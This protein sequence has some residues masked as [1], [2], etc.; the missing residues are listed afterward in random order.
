[1]TAKHQL[2]CADPRGDAPRTLLDLG[3]NRGWYSQ[4]AAHHGVRSSRADSDE[5]SLNEL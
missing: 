5:T 4:L 2:D 3:A 1:V